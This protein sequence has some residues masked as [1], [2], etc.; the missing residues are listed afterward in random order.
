MAQGKYKDMVEY[1]L[2][3]GS[4][5]NLQTRASYQS[6]SLSNTQKTDTCI[7]SRASIFKFHSGDEDQMHV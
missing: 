1:S 2:S 5:S 6:L 3:N 7:D 4:G